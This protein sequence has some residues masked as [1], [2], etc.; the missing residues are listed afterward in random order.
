MVALKVLRPTLS[1]T[2]AG[3]RFLREIQ[4]AARLTHP[5]I[6][7][8]YDSG[9]SEGFPYYLMPYIEGESLRARLARPACPWRR[10]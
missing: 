7:P 9:E 10:R 2:L 5:H 4:V 3:D 8:L 6:L 1:T